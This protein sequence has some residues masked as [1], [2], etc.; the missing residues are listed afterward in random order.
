[1]RVSETEVLVAAALWLHRRGVLPHS[2]SPARGQGIDAE[3][4]R[5]RIIGA[6]TSAGIPA[7]LL[8]KYVEFRASGPDVVGISGTEYWQI[9]CKGAGVGTSQTQR[10][11]FDR[12]LASVVS[13]YTDSVPEYVAS[14]RSYLGLAVPATNDYVALLKSR[15]RTPLRRQ[16]G[17]WILL[18]DP[19][20]DN[21]VTEVSPE[22]DY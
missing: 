9:E 4:A 10:T 8:G 18:Y 11:N 1:M 7:D 13:Y 17:L 14:A 19:R 16:L 3:T 15:V 20:A 12:A 6:L 22:A 5:A 21:T 2:F